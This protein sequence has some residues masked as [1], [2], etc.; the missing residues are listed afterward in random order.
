M[1]QTEV[2]VRTQQSKPTAK[3]IP[4]DEPQPKPFFRPGCIFPNESMGNDVSLSA[5][6]PEPTQAMEPQGGS[7]ENRG[8]ILNPPQTKSCKRKTRRG[9]SKRKKGKNKNLGFTIIG[10]NSNGLS[11]KVDSLYNT[12]KHFKPSCITI[13]ETKLRSKKFEIPGYQVF[14][15]NRPGLGGG[16]LTAVE[17]NLA[18]VLVS[19]P[20]TEILVIQTRVGSEDIRIINGY[21]PQEDANFQDIYNF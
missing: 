19:S 2:H 4:S 1:Q 3:A 10:T 13:Q 16:L 8:K 21:G 18:P 12:V 7:G 14:L 15:K 9:I 6:S 17:E 20:D 11:G 5:S